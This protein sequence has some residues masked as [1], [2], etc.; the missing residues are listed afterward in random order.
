MQFGGDFLSFLDKIDAFCA[1]RNISV[2]RFEREAGISKGLIPKW[3]SKGF[4][5]TYKSQLKI[6]ARMGISVED[7]M[8]DG[9]ADLHS[10]AIPDNWSHKPDIV[11]DATVRYI[12]VY[13]Y[14]GPES[15]E[16]DDILMHLAV[17]PET[18]DSADECFGMPIEDSSMSP[19]IMAGDIVIVRRDPS[20]ASGD[21]VIVTEPGNKTLCRR[22]IIRGDDIILQPLNNHYAPSIYRKEECDLVQL[23]FA[24]KVIAIIRRINS[25][26]YSIPE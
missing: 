16:P 25:S 3:R 17:L 24:G 20:P 2:T 12:P 13:R 11:R 9:P 19:D 7:L 10:K 5:P 15:P 14:A 8:R 1:E 6:A 26:S 21:I 18:L 22:L 23:V 4:M